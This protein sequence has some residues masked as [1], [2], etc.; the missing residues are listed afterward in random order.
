[1]KGG[2]PSLS[3]NV[4]CIHIKLLF[5]KKIFCMVSEG[6]NLYLVNARSKYLTKPTDKQ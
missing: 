2:E 3:G 4:R 5:S 1:M 6:I